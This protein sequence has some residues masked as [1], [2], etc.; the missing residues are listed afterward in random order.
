MLTRWGYVYF[1]LALAVLERPRQQILAAELLREIHDLAPAHS[2]MNLDQTDHSQRRG[3]SDALSVLISVGV[4]NE[5]DGRLDR[6]LRDEE[7]LF[8]IDR[9]AAALCLVASPSVLREVK[10]VQDF[11]TEPE[12]TNTEARSRAA[13]QRLDRRLIDQPVVLLDDLSPEEM[14]L[15][16]RNRRREA[17]NIHRLTGCSVE[18]R[19]EGMALVDSTVEPIGRTSFPGRGSTAQAALLWLDVLLE[20]RDPDAEGD[21]M[22]VSRVEA[23]AGW[24]RVISRYGSRFN[25]DA[26]EKPDLFRRHVEA[27]LA[28]FGLLLRTVTPTGDSGWH[29]VAAAARYRAVRVAGSDPESDSGAQELTLW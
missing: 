7:A 13:R 6:L 24:D 23:D 9:D 14:E 15:A 19:A 3:F 16:W 1:S 25:K 5:R 11:I 18:I 4:L 8:D 17:D 12:H 21:R 29:V 28:Q 27:D 22:F 26:R 2:G 20:H 10:T